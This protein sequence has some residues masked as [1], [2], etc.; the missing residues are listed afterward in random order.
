M[1]KP[2]ATHTGLAHGFSLPFLSD[3]KAMG[4]PYVFAHGLFL[5]RERPI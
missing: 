2:W 5:C 4:E 1:H 3:I